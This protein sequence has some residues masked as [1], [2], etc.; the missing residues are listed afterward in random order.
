MSRPAGPY[1]WPV[2]GTSRPAGPSPLASGTSRPAGPS[3]RAD[4]LA[5]RHRDLKPPCQR[6]LWQCRH[7]F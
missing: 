7:T 2:S 5:S 3:P 1:P 6:R 4:P